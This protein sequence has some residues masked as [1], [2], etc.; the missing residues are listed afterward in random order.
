M[1]HSL[2]ETQAPGID[3]QAGRLLGYARVST[4]DQELDLQLDALRD[5]GCSD[6]LIFVDKASG[7][8]T[9]RPGLEECLS[10]LCD[11]DVLL[12]WR[13]DRLG[14]STKHLVSIVEDLRERGI[15]FRSLSD[16]AI[17]TT[18]A[19]GELIFGIFAA[20]AQFERSLIVER[21]K[22][23]LA[24]ARTRGRKGGRPKVDADDPRVTT[25]RTLHRDKS[26]SISE[27]CS[28]LRVSR[29]T[30]YRWLK[31]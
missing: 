3:K 15:G 20:L 22:A 23:G 25:A 31:I 21:T 1:A 17:D 13:L 6:E 7:A 4:A 11:G 2:N 19:S 10:S 26:L 14:R 24:A 29:A 5:A 12:V 8:K 30:L 9:D 28:T 16:G 27:I 18:T